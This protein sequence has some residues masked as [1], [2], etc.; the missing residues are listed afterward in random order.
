MGMPKYNTRRDNNESPLVRLALTLG[1]WM[2]KSNE[3]GDWIGWRR[4]EWH[5][6]EIKNPNQQGHA[7]EYTLKQ[8]LLHAEA[9]K[10]GAK[11][12]VW[13]ADADVY[14]DSGAR[15]SA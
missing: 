12:L 13:R 3:L 14:R 2:H 9:F 8:R 7:D 15:V 4:G 1:W 6:I 11:I 10:R 5:I